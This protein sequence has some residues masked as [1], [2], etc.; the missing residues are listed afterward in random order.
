MV[1]FTKHKRELITS[2]KQNI[3]RKLFMK[4][5]LTWRASLQSLL[6]LLVSLSLFSSS[7]P[8]PDERRGQ[9]LCGAV[10]AKQ[11]WRKVWSQKTGQLEALLSETHGENHSFISYFHIHWWHKATWVKL[12]NKRTLMFSLHIW[13]SLCKNGDLDSSHQLTLVLSN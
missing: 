7:I 5:T 13:C 1:Q 6:F 3:L 2:V 11:G 10:S 4:D 8:V 9:G 12:P